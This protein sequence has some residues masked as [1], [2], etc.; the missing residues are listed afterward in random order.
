M[1]ESHKWDGFLSNK[2]NQLRKDLIEW[3]NDFWFGYL[4]AQ[5]EVRVQY[6]D[7]EGSFWFYFGDPRY[8]GDVSG[9]WGYGILKANSNIGQLADD[10]IKNLIEDI[11]SYTFV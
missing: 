2:G 4:D 9:F 1:L 8:D 11:D 7:V 3:L 5:L 10:M 6:L